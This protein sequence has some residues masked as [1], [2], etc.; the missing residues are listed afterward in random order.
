MKLDNK[1]N[2]EAETNV[3]NSPIKRRSASQIEVSLW[4]LHYMYVPYDN[5]TV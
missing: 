5:T 1:R 4:Y 3:T 2:N